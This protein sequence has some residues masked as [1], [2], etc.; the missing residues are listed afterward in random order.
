MYRVCACNI[1]LLNKITGV[2]M[3]DSSYVSPGLLW[4]PRLLFIVCLIWYQ[5][6]REGQPYLQGTTQA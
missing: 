1:E 4:L 3:I 6:V 5:W 2:R